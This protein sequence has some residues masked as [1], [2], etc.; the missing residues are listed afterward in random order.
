MVLWTVASTTGYGNRSTGRPSV[1]RGR[2]LIYGLL[3]ILLG[4]RAH[5]QV[6]FAGRA[7]GIV[8]GPQGFVHAEGTPPRLRL[9]V[10]VQLG[11]QSVHECRIVGPSYVRITK[12][13]FPTSTWDHRSGSKAAFFIWILGVGKAKGRTQ[14]K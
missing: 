9:V 12:G 2:E 7:I 3:V 11:V 5:V 8:G 14:F 13:P 1:Y 6:R 4:A 10:V